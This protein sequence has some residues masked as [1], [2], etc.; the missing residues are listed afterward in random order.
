MEDE[1]P[2]KKHKQQLGYGVT[3]D[4]SHPG[5]AKQYKVRLRLRSKVLNVGR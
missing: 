5:R 2:W 4:W 3:L 1:Q